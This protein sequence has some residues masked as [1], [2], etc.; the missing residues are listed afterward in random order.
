[1]ELSPETGFRALTSASVAL[2]T[3]FDAIAGGP[4]VSTVALIEHRGHQRGVAIP[5]EG[6]A[7]DHEAL[8]RLHEALMVAIR[9]D[10]DVR[11]VLASLRPDVPE[12]PV[13]EVDIARWRE[14]RS[15]H[16][17][18]AAVLLDWF[19]VG[20]DVALSLAE[21]VGPPAQWNLAA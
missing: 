11:L 13:Q 4:E 10:P 8:V 16:E 6:P 20:P 12:H 5:V 17:E 19:I 2:E 9:D 14:L 21:L 15:R 18:C 1:M 7:P 3:V